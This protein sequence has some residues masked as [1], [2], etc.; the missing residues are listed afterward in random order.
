[1][2]KV[3]SFIG[4]AILLMQITAL[5]LMQGFVLEP[6]APLRIS[7]RT[8][9]VTRIHY[10]RCGCSPDKIASHTCCCY[11]GNCYSSLKKIGSTCH[12]NN[13]KP[14]PIYISILSYG[15]TEEVYDIYVGKFEIIGTSFTLYLY[16][17]FTR[18]S[19]FKPVNPKNL[20]FRP[21]IP[22]PEIYLT[23]L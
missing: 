2:A 16:N 20:L 6:F 18:F 9:G 17:H 22:P 12:Y 11:S 19:Q 5:S 13:D 7:N 8:E 23:T 21:P 10:H 15:C 4:K 14:S 1:M 3:L